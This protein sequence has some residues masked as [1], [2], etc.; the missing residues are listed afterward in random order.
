MSAESLQRNIETALQ[1]NANYREASVA[2]KTKYDAAKDELTGAVEAL[3]TAAA[4][5][6]AAQGHL[7]EGRNA[8]HAGS[9]HLKNMKGAL[10]VAGAGASS[11]SEVRDAYGMMPRLIESAESVAKGENVFANRI[12]K[13]IGTIATATSDLENKTVAEM[14]AGYRTIEAHAEQ[15]PNFIQSALESWQQ[16]QQ[17]Q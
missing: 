1:E 7:L 14:T 10:D 17:Q 13:A 12:G 4:R 16:Q 3:K 2:S 8:G 6:Q 9:V 5:L 15:N 11:V